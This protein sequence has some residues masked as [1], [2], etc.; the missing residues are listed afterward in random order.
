MFFYEKNAKYKQVELPL[1]CALLVMLAACLL[2]GAAAL[3]KQ[4]QLQQ[5]MIR[6][7]VV[8]NSDS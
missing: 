8:A 3:K 6:L 7:H 2:V 5:K 1:E 4:D